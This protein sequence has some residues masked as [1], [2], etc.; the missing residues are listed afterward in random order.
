MKATLPVAEWGGGIGIA[1]CI[2]LDTYA[3]RKN[4]PRVDYIKLDIEGAELAMLHGAA[5]TIKNFKP[6][7][8]VSAYHKP[9]DLWT[10]AFYIKSLRPDYE[11]KFRHYSIDC[12]DYLLNDAEREILDYFNLSYLVPNHGEFVLYCR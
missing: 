5:E 10:L 12:T 6:K 2:D 3:K 4:L 9:Y 11:L 1:K 7:M 8:A